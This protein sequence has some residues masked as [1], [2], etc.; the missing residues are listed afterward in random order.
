MSVKN[1][2]LTD[3]QIKLLYDQLPLTNQSCTLAIYSIPYGAVLEWSKI[4]AQNQLDNPLKR[5]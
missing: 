1:P 5:G 3:D 4:I 2:L